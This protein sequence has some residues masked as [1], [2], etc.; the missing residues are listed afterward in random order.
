MTSVTVCADDFA[1]TPGVSSGILACLE[2][3]RI[4]ATS[5]MTVSPTWSEWSAALRPFAAAAD[6]G[7]HFTLTDHR[8]IGTAP[9]LAP[10]GLF[11]SFSRLLQLSLRRRLPANEIQEQ[12]T[13][14]LDA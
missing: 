3:H 9:M 5:C 13:R 14:Q 4:S 6:I 1:L 2:R 10:H 8:S 12:L 11:P 7:L